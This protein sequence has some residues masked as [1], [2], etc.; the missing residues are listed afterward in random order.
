MRVCPTLSLNDL[1][2]GLGLKHKGTKAYESYEIPTTRN[3]AMTFFKKTKQKK[4]WKW[5][6]K[7]LT[8]Y[9]FLNTCVFF[10]LSNKGFV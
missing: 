7:F 1:L 9:L 10:T 3:S 4:G 5:L 8:L 2:N 6:V